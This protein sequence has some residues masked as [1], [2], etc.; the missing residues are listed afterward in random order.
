MKADFVVLK[1]IIFK[2]FYTTKEVCWAIDGS[3]VYIDG[4]KLFLIKH[5]QHLAR[6]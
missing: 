1:P 5:G 2:I 4:E 3:E 6:T